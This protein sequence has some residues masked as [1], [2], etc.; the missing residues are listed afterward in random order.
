MRK[1]RMQAV[2]GFARLAVTERIRQHDEIAGGIEEL[3]RTKQLARKLRPYETS[4]RTT[5]AVD[6][7]HRIANNSMRVT[8]G[9]TEGMV[10]HADLGQGLAGGELE[11]VNDKVALPLLRAPARGRRISR[12]G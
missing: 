3:P 2:T 4:A 11:V 8:L 5:R 9:L 1:L 12:G 7:Q 6:D 10:V